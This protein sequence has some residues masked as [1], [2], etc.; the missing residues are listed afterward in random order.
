[1]ACPIRGDSSTGDV[2]ESQVGTPKVGG[3][4]TLEFNQ[5]EP[6]VMHIDLNS[7]FAS[8]EQ[9]ANP[10]LRDKPIAVVHTDA[11]Y[12]CI[13][14]PSVEAKLWGVKT[15]MTLQEGRDLCPWLIS[16]V[17]DPPKYRQVHSEFA[18]LLDDYSPH[19]IPKSIDE[20][21]LTLPTIQGFNPHQRSQIQGLNPCMIAQ[22]IKSRIKSE[23]G[24]Y[25]RVSIG[26]STNQVLAKLASGIH[27]PDGFDIIDHNNYSEIY[28]KLKLQDLCGINIRNEARL[29]RV[30]IFSVFQFYNAS[31]QMLTSAFESVLGRYW[32][33]RIHGYEVD[34]VEFTRQSFGQSYVLPHPMDIGEWRPILSKL[35]SKATR[36][37]RE[38][39]FSASGIH[40]YLRYGD[41]DSWHMGHNTPNLLYDDV[42]LLLSALN[43]YER[44]AQK[45]PVKKIAVTCFGLGK[46]SGQLSC[47]VDLVK[48]KELVSS[49]DA[50]N[51][52]WGEYSVTYGS[53]LGSS[54]HVKDSIAFGK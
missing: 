22:Q 43:L 20:F 10:L 1:M 15:G 6:D 52:K 54:G 7:C 40:L 19:I 53:F 14:A 50:L 25:L 41:G 44:K 42:S 37:L 49:L 35:V 9:Q 38:S 21:V 16:R 11:P 5:A 17:A 33:S 36:R 32:Y 34:D 27:K 8:V 28:R 23:I 29:H 2:A 31:I 48:Q 26:V 45:K 46:D 51:D 39:G 18:K 13:L 12:G 4:S 30:G 3:V 24:D 47:L